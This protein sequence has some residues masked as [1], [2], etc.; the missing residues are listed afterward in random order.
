MV[1]TWNFKCL[2]YQGKKNKK[3]FCCLESYY[4]ASLHDF[5]FPL[6]N[7]YEWVEEEEEE[8]SDG[9][10]VYINHYIRQTGNLLWR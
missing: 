4:Y 3:L 6:S 10:E 2:E 9:K 8:D 5:L 1:H 7:E